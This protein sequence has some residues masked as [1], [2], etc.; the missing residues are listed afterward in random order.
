IIGL[1]GANGAGKTT[2]SEMIVGLNKPTSGKIEYGFKYHK[3]PQ[4]K[5]GMQFQDASYPSGL[6]IK[7]IIRFAQKV[8]GLSMSNKELKDLLKVFQIS[9]F[10]NKKPRSLSGGQ[11]QKLNIFLS[12]LHKPELIVLDELSTGL[13]ISAREE[14]ISFT[15]KLIKASG[16]SAISAIVI[17]HHMG[18]IEELCGRLIILDRGTIKLETTVEELTKKQ[19][20]SDYMRTLIKDART[21]MDKTAEI[22]LGELDD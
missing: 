3:V 9:D 16:M 10:Y 4:E 7:D 13:D 5:I 6:S 1:I 8:H 18:E 19:S 22:N 2:I 21:E 15:K 12:I 20:L 14:I 11:R 17:S